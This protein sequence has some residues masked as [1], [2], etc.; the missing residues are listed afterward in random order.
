MALPR[1]DLCRN[2]EKICVYL[3]TLRCPGLATEI[4]QNNSTLRRRTRSTSFEIKD[5]ELGDHSM[6]LGALFMAGTLPQNLQV[7]DWM[8]VSGVDQTIDG[9]GWLYFVGRTYDWENQHEWKRL[10]FIGRFRI[11]DNPSE[12]TVKA[13]LRRKR[14]KLP[15][16]LLEQFLAGRD[17]PL[18]YYKVR[19]LYR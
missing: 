10:V 3:R 16:D 7:L 19:H 17:L 1:R 14:S 2:Q 11:P 9:K 12:A 8:A 13:L 18:A 5:I 6:G 4:S 15:V